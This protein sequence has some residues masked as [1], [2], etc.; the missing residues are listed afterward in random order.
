MYSIIF[1]VNINRSTLL[2]LILIIIVEHYRVEA[3]SI[4]DTV[5][6]HSRHARSYRDEIA[7]K[8]RN[9]KV[10]ERKCYRLRKNVVFCRMVSR[11][12]KKDCPIILS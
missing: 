4:V 5:T 6:R 11:E 7:K 2:L 9:E 12:V 8:C 1:Y 3:R 10:M